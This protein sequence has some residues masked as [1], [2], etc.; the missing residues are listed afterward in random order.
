MLLPLRGTLLP[1]PRLLLRPDGPHLAI[2]FS[3]RSCFDERGCACRYRTLES[4]AE[5]YDVTSKSCRWPQRKRKTPHRS[6][7][8]RNYKPVVLA[9]MWGSLLVCY[10]DQP[11]CF[12]YSVSCKPLFRYLVG[13]SFGVDIMGF[14]SHTPPI[15][16]TRTF[17]RF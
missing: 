15:N 12:S 14:L 11:N 4:E 17:S 16:E 8:D 13:K 6:Q 10:C 5:R 9:T 3:T 2:T 1:G 7:F